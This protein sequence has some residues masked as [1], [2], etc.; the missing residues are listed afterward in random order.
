MALLALGLW[1]RRRI[2]AVLRGLGG[3]LLGDWFRAQEGAQGGIERL[4]EA[5]GEM[6]APGRLALGAAVHTC[7]WVATGVWTWIAL[8]LL[9]SE[10]DLV[11]VLALEALLSALVAAAFVV[12]GGAGVQEAGYVGLGAAFGVPAEMAL[13]VALLRRAKDLCW[14]V[15][16]LGAWQWRE[17]RRL[18][19]PGAP[20]I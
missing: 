16:I 1:Q 8:R 18:R 6:Y 7:G 14:G 9:G 17:V 4:R 11:H 12:P 13:V 10:L 3:R 20:P 5:L 15:P 19:E 2:G